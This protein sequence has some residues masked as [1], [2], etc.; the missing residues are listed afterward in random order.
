M[1]WL[2]PENIQPSDYDPRK[3]VEAMTKRYG[4]ISEIVL[5][6]FTKTDPLHV[7]FG[8]N[9]DEYHGYAERFMQQLGDRNIKA[10]TEQEVT[11]L[12]RSSFHQDLITKGFV[13]ETDITSIAKRIVE[14]Q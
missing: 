13:Q 6:A 7:F 12:V 8:E 5:A 10:L 9:I 11:D 4:V 2:K 14:E 1:S 3:V